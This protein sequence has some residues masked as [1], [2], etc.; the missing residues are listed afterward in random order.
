M[1]NDT[2][3]KSVDAKHV[4]MTD[5]R[6]MSAKDERDS[7]PIPMVPAVRSAMKSILTHI[8]VRENLRSYTINREC[9]VLDTIGIP[10]CSC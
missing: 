10:T 1:G 9:G 5:G 2:S 4:L 6:E 8:L 3:N 7:R